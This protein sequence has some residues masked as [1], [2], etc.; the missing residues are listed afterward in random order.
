[1]SLFCLEG[2]RDWKQKLACGVGEVGN[3]QPMRKLN[4]VM[5]IYPRRHRRERLC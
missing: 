3:T 1:M 4:W 2:L 5:S